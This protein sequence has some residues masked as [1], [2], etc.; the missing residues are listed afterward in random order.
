MMVSGLSAVGLLGSVGTRIPGTKQALT[1]LVAWMEQ[2]QP[3]DKS[4][5]LSFAF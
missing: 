1:A 4:A 2:Y 5:P 3:E